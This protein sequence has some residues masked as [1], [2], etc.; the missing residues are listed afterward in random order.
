MRLRQ[1]RVIGVGRGHGGRAASDEFAESK[2]NCMEAPEF[3]RGVVVT[4]KQAKYKTG[5]NG[6]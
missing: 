5:D 1:R 3:A 2:L 6:G 4:P